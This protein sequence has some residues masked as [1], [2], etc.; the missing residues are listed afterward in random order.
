MSTE[1]RDSLA[2]TWGA[3]VAARRKAHRLTQADLADLCRVT[4][5]TISRIEAGH[6]SPPDRLKLALADALDI[7]P[8]DLFAWPAK[9]AS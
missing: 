7:A 4:Q 9:A 1:I 2:A 8:G 6:S 5:Q 3:S